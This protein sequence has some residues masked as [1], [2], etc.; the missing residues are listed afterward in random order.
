MTLGSRIKRLPLILLLGLFLFFT[1][2]LFLNLQA[3][4]ETQ[5]DDPLHYVS[6]TKSV[7]PASFNVATGTGN[8]SFDFQSIDIRTLL[9]LIAKN[10]NLNFVVSDSVKGNI[11]LNLKN[12]TW[13]QALKIVLESHGLG[14]RKE[15]NVIF[16]STLDELTTNQTKQLQSDE[17]ISNLAPLASEIVHLKY[18]NAKDVADLLKSQNGTLLT[19]RGQIAVDS[20]TNSLIIRDVSRNLNDLVHAIRQLDVPAKQVLI[21]ARIVNIDVN[22]E[23]QLG[24]RF[25]VTHTPWLSG[26]FFG[27]NSLAQGTAPANVVNATQTIDPTQRLNF[28]VPATALFGNVPGSIGIAVANLGGILLDLELS[29]LEG[30]DHAE[31]ISS[32]RVMTSNQ[33]KAVIQTGEEIPY[34]ESTSSGATSVSFKNAVLSLE[35][36]PQITP[37]NKI[38]LNV[39]ATQDTRGTNT[40]L[41]ATAGSTASSVPAINTQEVES[42]IILNNNETVVL[43]G[44]YKQIKENT[45]VR[46]PFFGS[47]PVV[48]ALFR[49]QNL[50]NEKTELLIFLTPKIIGISKG[51]NGAVGTKGE[52]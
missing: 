6:N 4:P 27:A 51:V 44:V 9:Q 14:S 10:A 25:G 52:S 3:Y 29:A 16:I 46:I 40:V 50:Q 2:G 17:T 31:L 7:T 15:G 42:N 22:F 48:G 34:Q 45:I 33:K 8:L 23:K 26:T 43:G 37:D 19:P 5:L 47:L 12:V 36:I 13:D 32:P 35:I 24:A 30:E 18:S 1:P 39:K 49:S 41:S 20:R 21:E 28:N 11:S 38:I